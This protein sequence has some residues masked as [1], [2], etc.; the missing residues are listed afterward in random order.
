MTSIE[1]P[2]L[3]L[4][5]DPATQAFDGLREEV[6][7]LR[8][9][10]AGLT[11]ERAAL[12][13]PDYSETL[14]QITRMVSSIGKRLVAIGETPAFGLTPDDLAHRITEAAIEARRQDRE[15]ILISRDALRE[16]AQEFGRRLK[17]VRDAD[18]QEQLLVWFGAGGLVVGIVLTMAVMAF[19]HRL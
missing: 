4:T 1:Q 19:F 11:A 18:R 13:V 9:A 3:P 6:A 17:S 14:A 10:I 12:D 15:T 8:R 5:P 7:L 2:E 16:T